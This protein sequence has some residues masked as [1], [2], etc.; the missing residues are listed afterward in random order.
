[1]LNVNWE[2]IYSII[3]FVTCDG[4]RNFAPAHTHPLKTS[5]EFLKPYELL[6]SELESLVKLYKNL[7]NNFI[8]HLLWLEKISPTHTH[9]LISICEFWKPYE[10]LYFELESLIKC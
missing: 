3:L 6:F 2:K 7:L 10:L 8:C 4:L 9:L 5:H 1:M